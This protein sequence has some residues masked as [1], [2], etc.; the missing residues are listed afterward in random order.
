MSNDR[1]L[2]SAKIGTVIG[3]AVE[4]TYAEIGRVATDQTTAVL[5]SPQFATQ[6]RELVRDAALGVAREMIAESMPDFEPRVRAIVAEHFERAVASA[7]HAI[8]DEK[9]ADIRRRLT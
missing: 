1:R 4:A 5:R 8:L 2:D 7:A 3:G 6:V 9:L